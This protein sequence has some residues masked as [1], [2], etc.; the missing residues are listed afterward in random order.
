M[1]ALLLAALVL[2]PGYS[3]R[4]VDSN[5]WIHF[6]PSADTRI[7]YVATNG[8][9][10]TAQYYMRTDGAIG[11]DPYNPTGAI[12]AYA[13]VSAA[14]NG[15]RRGYPD[16]VLLKRGHTWYA[17]LN[18]YNPIGRSPSEPSLVGA[19]G[20]GPRPLL[21]TGSASLY[22]NGWYFC[23][24]AAFMSL[25]GY[26]HTRDPDS[27]EY[28]GTSGSTG[29]HIGSMPSRPCTGIT[30]ED[31]VIRFY[32]G[33]LVTQGDG[34]VTDTIIR[35]NLVL[36]AYT[37]PNHCAGMF[38]S[39]TAVLLDEN[40]FDH[41]GWLIQGVPPSTDGS[42]GKATMYSHDTYFSTCTNCI[43]RENLFLRAA[44]MGNKWRADAT[45][46]S[47]FIR[48]VN[49]LYFEGEIG[50]GIGGNTSNPLRFHDVLIT[51]NVITDCGTSRP[52][53]RTL[54]WNL[55]I[56]DWDG[57]YVADNLFINQTNTTV[58]NVYAIHLT[59]G[60]TRN[61]TLTRNTS[62]GIYSTRGLMTLDNA[63]SMSGIA[64]SHNEV[65]SQV[66]GA[67]IVDAD[68]SLSAY[69]LASNSYYSSRSPSQWFEVGSSMTGI[70]G[71]ET[72]SHEV[73]AVTQAVIYPYPN[74]TVYTYLES[75][76][77]SNTVEQ[78]LSIVR[79]QARGSWNTNFT[80][81]A[82]NDYLRRG[83]ACLRVTT[84]NLPNGIIGEPYACPLQHYGGRDTNW[85][86]LAQGGL[87]A[88]LALSSNGVISGTPVDPA[89]ASFRVL[90][91]DPS[92]ARDEMPLELV[93]VP[94]PAL[95][96]PPVLLM[97]L[98][99]RRRV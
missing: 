4:P 39:H 42:G 92:G 57:G 41:D 35:R 71:W 55:E 60:S 61:V 40:I 81:D 36:D 77:Y 76:G 53:G 88:G 44:S 75:L 80:A 70:S 62:Y 21:K 85:W 58:G 89:F 5:G 6:M 23:R 27:P 1:S 31:C 50:I 90:V 11:D 79:S 47:D 91:E 74:R 38:A 99:L 46:A 65:Q 13:T 2:Y 64:W 69:T 48:I 22:D 15:V 82:I 19:Y 54:G 98:R 37:S 18:S 94:E 73:G 63:A 29:I 67:K 14:L 17:N 28:A 72:M 45:G 97:W 12:H 30:I 96:L 9:D 34:W 87:P 78:F 52:T 51:S 59:A 86:R 24:N 20:E 25:H 95:A 26:A 16:W 3:D 10:A 56:S 49:N 33:G 32:G 66:Y 93:I 83:F 7:H 84:T 8:N 43:F 68:S